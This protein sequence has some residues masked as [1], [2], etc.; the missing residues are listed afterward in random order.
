MKTV[1]TVSVIENGFLVTEYET[2][3]TF[4]MKEF[5]M[6]LLRDVAPKMVDHEAAIRVI[7]FKQDGNQKIQ[8]IKAVRDYCINNNYDKY[9]GLKDAKDHVE[10][11]RDDWYSQWAREQQMAAARDSRLD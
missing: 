7:I 10:A 11:V 9:R 6:D 4:Y 2:G 5:T 8:A 3:R 1:A